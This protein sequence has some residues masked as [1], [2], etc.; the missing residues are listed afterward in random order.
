MEK[1]IEGTHYT[2]YF[3]G[4]EIC[5]MEKIPLANEHSEMIKRELSKEIKQIILNWKNKYNILFGHLDIVKEKN[6]NKHF[7]VDTGSF[8]EFTN[9]KCSGDP[10]SLIGNLILK[11]YWN[12]KN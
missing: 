1:Y 2:V 10:V 5:A 4:D 6:T 12:L 9:W 7:V 3:I 8:P 11:E